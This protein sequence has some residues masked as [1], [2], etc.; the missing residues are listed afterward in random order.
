MT[1]TVT[2][3]SDFS[4]RQSQMLIRQEDKMKVTSIVGVFCLFTSGNCFSNDS[5]HSY[6]SVLSNI[7]LGNGEFSILHSP[8]GVNFRGEEQLNTSELPKIIS[9][10]MGHTT[11][12]VTLLFPFQIHLL[13]Y[14]ISNNLSC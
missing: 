4:L 12:S 6:Y 5:D 7:V 13:H 11:P 9:T 8:N 2:R 14:L 1:S 10:A 3:L